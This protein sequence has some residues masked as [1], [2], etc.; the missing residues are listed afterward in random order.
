MSYKA[1]ML[2][3]SLIVTLCSSIRYFVFIVVGPVFSIGFGLQ[4]CA[5]LASLTKGDLFLGHNRRLFYD[6]P[7]FYG[8]CLLYD[9]TL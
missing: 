8:D 3:F 7:G 4:I 6:Q 9:A 1:D 2:F 5:G